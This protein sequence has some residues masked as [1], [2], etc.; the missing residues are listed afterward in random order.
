MSKDKDKGIPTAK[1]IYEYNLKRYHFELEHLWQRSIF[2]AG[3]LIAIA[4]SYGVFIKDCYLKCDKQ[5]IETTKTKEVTKT[6]NSNKILIKYIIPIGLSTL[7]IIFS[8]LWV[9][10]SKASKALQEQIEYA[11]MQM[12]EYQNLWKEGIEVF[13]RAYENFIFGDPG[14]DPS[15]SPNNSLFSLSSGS[16]SVSKINTLIGL[17]TFIVFFLCCTAHTFELMRECVGLPQLFSVI[18]AFA[19]VS[20]VAICLVAFIRKAVFSTQIN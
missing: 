15:N 16:F 13:G 14:L 6:E 17:I 4:T 10:M 11:L 18:V 8:I 19:V 3:F 20:F 12:R 2:I 7:G 1:D 5:Y 9:F